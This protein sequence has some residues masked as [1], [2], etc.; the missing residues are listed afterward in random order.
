MPPTAPKNIEATH[1]S[2]DIVEFIRLLD[3]H[4]VRFILVGGEA[5]IFHGYIRFTGDV[6]FFYSE[7]LWNANSLFQALLE[8][9]DGDIPGLQRPE[10]LSEVG[11]VVQF[12]RP[13]NRI[14]LLNRIDGVT[15]E[16]AWST[17]IPVGLAT[18]QGELPLCLLS[19]PH[20]LKNKRASGRPKDL[21]DLRFFE[22]ARQGT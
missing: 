16:E 10:E 2:A 21:E 20:L 4:G 11:I 5:V 8:F 9:W 14:D 3:K 17:R 1:F 18:G 15:F 13:P 19:L 22:Q 12:G 7:D 6:D